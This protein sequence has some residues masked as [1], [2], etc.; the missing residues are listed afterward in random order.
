MTVQRIC[1]LHTAAGCVVYV[2]NARAEVLSAVDAPVVDETRGR[3]VERAL[4]CTA[5]QAGHVPPPTN[6]RQVVPV[7][8]SCAASGA[9]GVAIAVSIRIHPRM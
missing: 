8:Y 2:G 3:R 4:T 5:A 6:R 1:I 7:R 9:R